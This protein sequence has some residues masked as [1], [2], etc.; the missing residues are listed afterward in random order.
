[1]FYAVLLMLVC[2]GSFWQTVVVADEMCAATE[3]YILKCSETT[4]IQGTILTTIVNTS[5]RLNGT[6]S[7]TTVATTTLPTTT[8]PTPTVVGNTTVANTTMEAATDM[9]TEMMDNCCYN[10]GLHNTCTDISFEENC[11]ICNE[12]CVHGCSVDDPDDCKCFE[13]TC[14]HY[15]YDLEKCECKTKCKTLACF[16]KNEKLIFGFIIIAIIVGVVLLIVS[17]SCLIR[18]YCGRNDEPPTPVQKPPNLLPTSTSSSMPA[19]VIDAEPAYGNVNV[20]GQVDMENAPKRES[21]NQNER[22]LPEVPLDYGNEYGNIGNNN[23]AF[24]GT[25]PPLPQPHRMAIS[26]PSTLSLPKQ[27]SMPESS[28]PPL[29]PTNTPL[30]DLLKKRLEQTV[31]RKIDDSNIFGEVEMKP[32]KKQNS[33]GN[34]RNPNK[35]RNDYVPTQLKSPSA[36]GRHELPVPSESKD[37]GGDYEIPI[38]SENKDYGGDYEIP[39]PSENKDYGGDYEIPVPSE[40]KDYGGDYEIPVPSENKDY[41]GDYEIPVPSENKDYGG[42]Y[43]IALQSSPSKIPD[44]DY[45]DTYEFVSPQKTKVLPPIVKK[46]PV[47]G[48]HQKSSPSKAK[49]SSKGSSYKAPIMQEPSGQPDYGDNYEAPM[50]TNFMRP[51]QDYGDQYETPILQEKPDDLDFDCIYENTTSIQLQEF[52]RRPAEPPAEDFNQVYDAPYVYNQPVS[53]KGMP[54]HGDYY[55]QKADKSGNP[56]LK[57]NYTKLYRS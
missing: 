17:L 53:F 21:Q 27:H 8:R 50:T 32:Q 47:V 22:L 23:E 55:N 1:M 14:G 9:V 38:P 39:V 42:D 43:E 12:K 48:L 25:A 37:Y 30:G 29:P 19:R 51:E 35:K 6:E 49:Q 24:Q 2:G 34:H 13:E 31:I 45:G 54:K 4:T 41:G 40:N 20:L 11:T 18:Y 3:Y 33:G 26:P 56:A 46:K 44:S 52:P 7:S 57:E 10:I 15:G 16:L 36:R 28:P 5:T